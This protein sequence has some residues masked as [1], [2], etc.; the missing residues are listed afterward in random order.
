[1]VKALWYKPEGCGFETQRDKLIFPIYLITPAKLV[2]GAYVTSN[3]IEYQNQKNN[4]P[5]E[6]S[7]AGA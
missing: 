5:G 4:V 2:L 1:V 3:I 6:K 7:A